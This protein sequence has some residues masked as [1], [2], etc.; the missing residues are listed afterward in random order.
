MDRDGLLNQTELQHMLEVFLFVAKENKVQFN[1]QK[2]D[3]ATFD[4]QS[5]GRQSRE[6]ISRTEQQKSGANSP[7]LKNRRETIPNNRNSVDQTVTNIP[8]S[9]L[10]ETYA[11]RL[12]DLKGRLTPEGFL[13]QED[14]LVW[15]VDNNILVAP[16]LELLFQVCHVS[17]GLKPHCRH[18]EHEIGE[19]IKPV[20]GKFQRDFNHLSF[21]SDGLVGSGRASRLPRRPILVFNL[22]GLVA[23]LD[24]VHDVAA[25]LVRSLHLPPGQNT[26]RR[27]NRLRRKFHQQLHG[28]HDAFQRVH[29][30]QHRV[31]GRFTQPGR[32]LQHRFQFGGV[33]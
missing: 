25:I 11:K 19:V 13:T 12:L 31:Y 7:D 27:R 26:G 2:S 6:S 30:E 21:F 20:S 14:F 18:H 24:H 28:L 9:S 33:E 4:R 29:F 5:L 16:L 17:L 15:S 32:Q 8:K 1:S 23:I 3:T 22:F 10:D